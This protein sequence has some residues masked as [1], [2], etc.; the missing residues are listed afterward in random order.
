M[1][2]CQVDRLLLGIPVEA[3]LVDRLL[4]G[5]PVEVCRVDR[6]LLGYRWKY[7]KLTGCFMLGKTDLVNDEERILK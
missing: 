3:C 4:L 2:I 6:L 5:I 7:A 1:E